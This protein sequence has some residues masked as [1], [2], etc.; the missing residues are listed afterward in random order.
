MTS[1]YIHILPAMLTLVL[2]WNVIS[3]ESI[4]PLSWQDFIIA[5]VGYI[6]W[7]VSYYIKTEVIDRHVLDSNP[8]L[9]TSLRWLAK[10]KKNATARGV[11]KILK[12]VGVMGKD[13]DY[14]AHEFKTKLIFMTSQF[15]YTVVTFLP[16]FVLYQSYTIHVG[17]M[18]ALFVASV[19]NGASYYIEVF[20]QRYQLKFSK[21]EDMQKVVQA[22][23][24][25]AYQAATTQGQGS[26]API[27]GRSTQEVLPVSQ[28]A[29]SQEAQEVRNGTK[30]EINSE[31]PRE[32]HDK[33]DILTDNSPDE[34]KDD[35]VRG[36]IEAATTAFVDEW[37]NMEQSEYEHG[38]ESEDTVS[39]HDSSY[40]SDRSRGNSE[41]LTLPDRSMH[42][43]C[44][45]PGSEKLSK[46]PE[47]PELDV[48]FTKETAQNKD[49]NV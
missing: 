39:E 45:A 7:Q 44:S 25:I 33:D 2:R 8:E 48:C 10:D 16:S 46:L 13:E 26:P 15:I 17:Y 42:T 21:K 40:Y 1:I 9:L 49:K 27:H 43:A 11:L 3:P 47:A 41:D 37:H 12:R 18:I 29:D 32:L 4:S 28:N 19:F 36:I 34:W 35:S 30:K 22:A 23:A 14:Q 6:F 24:E 20:S 38:F 5:A 31:S